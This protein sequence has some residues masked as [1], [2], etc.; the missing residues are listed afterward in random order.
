[1]L[2]SIELLCQQIRVGGRGRGSYSVLS[3]LI[4]GGGG[5]KNAD[6]IR[7]EVNFLD[8]TLDLRTGSYKPYMKENDTPLYV[9]SGSNH[10]PRILKNIPISVNRRLS[11]ISSSKEL[12]EKA[13]P[14]YQNALRKS[15]Y[16][17]K[18]QYEI[19]KTNKSK[20]KNRKRPVTWFNPPFSVNIQSNVGKEFLQLLDRAFPP[21]NPLHRLFTR[22]TVKLAYKCMPNMAASVARHN[23]KVLRSE[24][25]DPKP[26][27]CEG[28]VG[29]C[30]V[31]GACKQKGVIYEAC[32]KQRSS[33]K[34]ET[35]TGLTGRCFK[36]R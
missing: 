20:K 32:V 36:D 27:N 14:P 1:M 3:A 12:F 21:S 35:Y 7:K 33:G 10:P 8:I 13:V 29:S 16:D 22:Q 9:H 6:V 2:P 28:G 34:K 11:K 17:H 15:G 18:L 23:N 26:C 19:P 4:Q 5:S 30:P 24:K 25:S 31:L